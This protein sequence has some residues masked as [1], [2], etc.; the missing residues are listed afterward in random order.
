MIIRLSA[1]RYSRDQSLYEIS[2]KS[3]NPRPPAELV[4]NFL[5]PLCHAVTLTFDSL[6]LNFYSTSGVVFKLCRKLAK[7]ERNRIICSWELLS[8]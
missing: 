1:F 4:A 2:A 8:I 5:H 7:F 3:S 6:T